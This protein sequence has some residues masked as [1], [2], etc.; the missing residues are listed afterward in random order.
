MVIAVGS[1]RA[2]SCAKDGPLRAPTAGVV[3]SSRFRT[4]AITSVMRCREPSSRPLVAL[5]ISACGA[6]S[7]RM[8]SNRA[9]QCCEGMTLTTICAPPRA[10]ARSLVAVT[11]SGMWRPGRNRS[12]TRFCAIDSQTSVSCAQRRTWCVPLRPRTM[13][14]P[15]PHAP[16]PMTAMSLMRALILNGFR[17]PR[18]GGG[19]WRDV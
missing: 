10:A 8:R 17:F 15:V 6:I 9:R 4:S 2:T 18:A 3:P 14:M 11:E 16:P 1:P 13:A 12:L 5:T 7:G 19:C